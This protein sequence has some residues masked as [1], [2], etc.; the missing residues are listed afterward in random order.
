M[1]PRDLARAA[2]LALV[3]ALAGGAIARA[4]TG[5]SMGGDSFS[6]P[7]PS[8]SSS[9]DYSSSSSSSSSS[10]YSPSYDYSGT[11]NSDS[12]HRSSSGGGEWSAGTVLLGLVGFAI[13]GVFVL[14]DRLR[15]PVNSS[16]SS[17]SFMSSPGGAMPQA[18]VTVLRIGVD[19]RARKHVQAELARIAKSAQTGTPEGR[20]TMLREVALM[21]RRLR[22]AW[23]YGGAVNEAFSPK[24]IAEM[25]YRKH[26]ADARGAFKDELIRN[27]QGTTTT[28]TA[29][30]PLATTD[31][32]PGV[33]LITIVVAARHELL[34][35]TRIGDGAELRLALEALS[36]MIASELI[37]VEI[38]WMPAAEDER[39][40]SIALE[41]RFP[42]PAL[43]KI[44][45]ALVGKV[46]CAFC[47][48]PYPAESI[49]CPACGGR[50]SQQQT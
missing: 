3:L 21:L 1:R 6:D 30:A 7:D 36:T 25:T 19:A 50:P 14:A 16:S 38:V 31:D 12:S 8:P 4:Q 10:D 34:T 35:V 39:L 20:A 42:P 43:F 47:G 17:S 45:G 5:G 15:P 49:A 29:A 9:S 26:V 48:A 24:A 13:F 41:T 44:D 37:G 22:D 27:E 2:I 40:S 33:M 46:F 11:S 28:A 32:G 18:D 23:V